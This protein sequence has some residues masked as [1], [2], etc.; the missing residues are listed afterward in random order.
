[1]GELQALTTTCLPV[2]V[3]SGPLPG[4]TATLEAEVVA[5][6]GH[7]RGFWRTS[8]SSTWR[9]EAKPAFGH[10]L[11]PPRLHTSSTHPYRFLDVCANSGSLERARAKI[12]GH[13]LATLVSRRR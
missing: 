4:T 12:D 6:R 3:I 7:Q 5:K 8:V 9:G 1:M 13:G 11:G 10:S 2:F